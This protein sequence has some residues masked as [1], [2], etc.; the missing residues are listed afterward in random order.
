MM[1]WLFPYGLGGIG[2]AE[3]NKKLSA[4]AHKRHLLMYYDKRFQR[5]PHFPLI[6]FNHEQIKG[7]TTAG[8]LM[9]EKNSFDDISDRLLNVNLE[10]LSDLAKRMSD[11]ERVTPETDEEKNCFQLINDL[12]HVG[13]HVDG[14]I[15]KKKYMRNEIWSLI[16]Y[17]GAPSW[18]ITFSPADNKHP[19]CL[20]FA[21][22]NEAFKP[23]LRIYD[24]R[25]RLISQNPVAGARFFHHMC[26][27]F[28]KHV[29]GVG[30]K[31]PGLYGDTSAYYGAVEQQGRLTL[32][33]HMLLWIRG[34]LSPQ[35]I[36]DKIMDPTSDFQKAM[37]EY[38][39]SVHI[40]EFMTGKMEDVKAKV[41]KEVATNKEYKDPTQT[42]PIPPPPECPNNN[43]DT[44]ENCKEMDEWE[45]QFKN[46][47]DDL[48][49]RS[50]VH[51]CR[52][53]IAADEKKQKKEC[54]GCLSKNGQ[55]KARFPRELHEE[56]QVDPKTGALNYES[57]NLLKTR[58]FTP[59]FI[60]IWNIRSFHR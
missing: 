18:F 34:A 58:S 11:G 26:E 43:C 35:E 14:S 19:M 22:T 1:P 23:E 2:Q 54:R 46:T 27:M 31:H 49:L 38:L 40:G 32:H 9:V 16:S 12:D 7:A 59:G 13:S 57:F 6:A 25:Y 21:D 50:N 8:Y 3:H 4:I 10:V 55:C 51:E 30:T 39:E 17:M 53:S 60:E 36:R 33:M 15:T 56:T 42:L 37:V 44:C 45:E 52:T 47:V 20:Y 28:I 29:L 5:D 41:D 24:D 48:L